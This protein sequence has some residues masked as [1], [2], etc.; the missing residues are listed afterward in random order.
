MK[1]GKV[2]KEEEEGIED[3]SEEKRKKGIE[4]RRR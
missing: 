4:E 1:R 2:G 3:R